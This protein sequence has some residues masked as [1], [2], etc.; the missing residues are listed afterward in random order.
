[1]LNTASNASTSFKMFLAPAFALSL[2]ACQSTPPASVSVTPSAYAAEMPELT[3]AAHGSVSGSAVKLT[4]NRTRPG[5]PA[6]I[7]F[8]QRL[9]PGIPSGHMYV[10]FGRLDASITASSPRAA[11][12]AFM[13]APSFPCPRN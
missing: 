13:A 10:V 1:L 3:C 4:A 8:R 11:C 5:D 12:W 7:E 2:A 6:Y 9:S